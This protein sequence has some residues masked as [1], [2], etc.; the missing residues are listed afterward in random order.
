[1]FLLIKEA[2]FY[3]RNHI[4]H[5]IRMDLFDISENRF[6]RDLLDSNNG[7]LNG[8]LKINTPNIF[9]YLYFKKIATF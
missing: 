3:S 6:F 5:F 1:M 9:L 8:H 2:N 4:F 7:N